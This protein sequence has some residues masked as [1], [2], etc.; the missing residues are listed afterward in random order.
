MTR[1]VV[2]LALPGFDHDYAQWR[3]DYSKQIGV[4]RR[5]VNR[6][7]VEIKPLY[8]PRDWDGSAYEADLCFPGQYPFTRGVYPTM[9]RGR[10]WT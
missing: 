3:A 10:T 1:E 2:Q 9:H 4:N 6:S 5:T 7:G 8:T